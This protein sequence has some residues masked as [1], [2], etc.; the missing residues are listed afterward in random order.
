VPDQSAGK[1]TA[2]PGCGAVVTC[3]SRSPDARA[4]GPAGE[5]ALPAFEAGDLDP[6]ASPKATSLDNE[7]D[8]LVMHGGVLSAFGRARLR[9]IAVA[10]K[11][12]ITVILLQ[13]ACYAATAVLPPP[14]K[15]YPAIGTLAL[16]V[17]SL[18]FIASL[19]LSVYSTALGIF[20]AI[21]SLI[22]CINLLVLVATNAKATRVLR[23]AG[24]RVGF[25]GVELSEFHSS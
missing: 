8:D 24:Y 2:C 22:P 14:L 6:Y 19:A 15:V 9:K 21:L 13:F 7:L 17:V 4:P 25:L 3:P 5:F 18:Y 23:D 16:A 20:F 12:I 11:G 1:T 10:Q